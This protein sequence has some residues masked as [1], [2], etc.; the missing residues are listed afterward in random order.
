MN[1]TALQAHAGLP[2]AQ[3]HI[4]TQ[5]YSKDRYVQAVRHGTGRT[6]ARMREVMQEA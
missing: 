5:E 2:A 1:L 4:L 3:A 6:S